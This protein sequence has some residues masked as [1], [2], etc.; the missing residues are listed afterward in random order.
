MH[1]VESIKRP[2][3]VETWG[4][5]KRDMHDWCQL[6][7][8]RFLFYFTAWTGLRRD[9]AH[10]R[11]LESWLAIHLTACDERHPEPS[12]NVRVN[13]RHD[14]V[15]QYLRMRFDEREGFRSGLDPEDKAR[16]DA[17]LTYLEGMQY[18]MRTADD[19]Y[20]MLL[21]LRTLYN[22][23]SLE[24]LENIGSERVIRG[25]NSADVVKQNEPRLRLDGLKIA[26]SQEVV[27]PDRS[28]FSEPIVWPVG[29]DFG[30]DSHAMY[31]KK[32][33]TDS[34]VWIGVS[35]DEAGISGH[36]P[37]QK[38][39]TKQLLTSSKS[40]LKHRTKGDRIRYFHLPANNMKWAEVSHRH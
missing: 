18:K 40:P 36:F 3:D 20:K 39:A 6:L 2:K 32:K 30:I 22:D 21:N 23:W 9:S 31:F 5:K 8:I 37:T 7:G 19:E 13:M 1:Q 25:R 29:E 4:E 12:Q 24:V 26:L 33:D 11:R 38:I 28:T 34:K 35:N 27:Y 16:V 10:A 17:E 15:D 14:V